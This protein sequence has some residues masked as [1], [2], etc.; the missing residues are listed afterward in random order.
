[1]F[2]CMFSF[3]QLKKY[4]AD[5]AQE[6]GSDRTETIDEAKNLIQVRGF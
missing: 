5:V 6:D 3:M 4:Q 1:M 2:S